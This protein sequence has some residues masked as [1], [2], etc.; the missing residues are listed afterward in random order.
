LQQIINVRSSSHELLLLLAA[1][2]KG[3]FGL[4]FPLGRVHL[5]TMTVLNYANA[6]HPEVMPSEER[7][8]EISELL[9]HGLVRLRARQS[10]ELFARHGESSLDFAANQSGRPNDL[11]SQEMAR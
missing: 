11:R 4:F 6:I 10:S 2:S 3:V 1:Y 9:A 8:I 5:Q 7:L